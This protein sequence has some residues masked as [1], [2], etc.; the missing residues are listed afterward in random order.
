MS[1]HVSIIFLFYPGFT[2]G[3]QQVLNN[4]KQ[5]KIYWLKTNLFDEFSGLSVSLKL[6]VVVL[7]EL[8]R[9]HIGISGISE[10]LSCRSIN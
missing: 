7:A 3:Y 5:S 1:L 4:C 2:H 6:S 8:G 9:Q 10:T